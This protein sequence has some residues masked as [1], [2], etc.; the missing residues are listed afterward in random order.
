MV[1][2]RRLPSAKGP[3]KFLSAQRSQKTQ[4]ET[5][6]GESN[7]EVAL[8]HDTVFPL[9][10]FFHFSYP[11]ASSKKLSQCDENVQHS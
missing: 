3:L 10:C 1:P 9:P 8:P 2:S 4:Y 7:N 5:Q 6:L 11:F